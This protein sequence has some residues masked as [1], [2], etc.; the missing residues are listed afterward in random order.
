M[1]ES[2][3]S[4]RLRRY[5]TRLHSTFVHDAPEAAARAAAGEP[6]KVPLRSRNI[7]KVAVAFLVVAIGI[8]SLGVAADASAPGQLLYP[9][10]RTM[11]RAFATL[12]I[13]TADQRLSER[14]QEAQ[15]LLDLGQPDAALDTLLEAVHT[16][17]GVVSPEDAADHAS[18]ILE[19]AEGAVSSGDPS[20][21]NA[22]LGVY[23]RLRES[24]GAEGLDSNPVT[25]DELGVG[26]GDD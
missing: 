17:L 16:E 20:Q 12:G 6:S 22:R 5:A 13:G 4:F 1:T 26:G 7:G 8:G 21:A 2:D 25:T 15:A 24:I 14:T 19:T 10:D 11:E 3:P 23:Q 9:V 18:S